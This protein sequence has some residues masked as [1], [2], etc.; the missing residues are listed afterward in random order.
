MVLADFYYDHL[1]YRCL[2]NERSSQGRLCFQCPDPLPWIQSWR[3]DTPQQ[4]TQ[5]SVYFIGRWHSLCPC[6]WTL[7]IG[8][9]GWVRHWP[10][11]GWVFILQSPAWPPLFGRPILYT[12]TTQRAWCTEAFVSILAQSQSQKS[13]PGGGGVQNLSSHFH[14]SQGQEELS[15]RRPW[16][17]LAAR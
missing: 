5:T 9:R 1:N 10:Q 6:P 8:G 7:V 16:R 12:T 11:V 17:S 14:N 13:H 15:R 2:R 3:Q 4:L